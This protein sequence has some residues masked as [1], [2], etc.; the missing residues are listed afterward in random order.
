MSTTYYVRTSGSDSTGNGSIDNPYA[1]I[2]KAITT[3]SNGNIIDVGSGTYSSTGFNTVSKNVTIN[4]PNVGISGSS[5]SRSNEAIIIN[6]TKSIFTGIVTIDGFKISCDTSANLNGGIFQVQS[7]STIQNC[8]FER[9]SVATGSSILNYG[10][11]IT[12]NTNSANYN[13]K[14]NLFI[15]NTTESLFTSSHKSWRSAIYIN[16][17]GRAG[18]IENNVFNNCMT[19]INIDGTGSSIVLK[20]NNFFKCGTFVTYGGSAAGAAQCQGNVY[21]IYSLGAS[22]NIIN[23]SS[24]VDAS[25]VANLLQDKF[26]FDSSLNALAPSELSLEQKFLIEVRLLHKKRIVGSTA[27]N[28]IVRYSNNEQCVIAGLTTIANALSYAPVSGETIYVGPGTYN[29]QVVINKSLTINGSQMDINSINNDG[30]MRNAPN[31]TIVQG[32]TN[33]SGICFTITASNVVINGFKCI[34]PA[35]ALVRDAFNIKVTPAGVGNTSNLQNIVIKN[36]IIQ[37]LRT[38]GQSHAIIFGESTTNL[39]NASN[40]DGVWNNV[41]IANNYF[42]SSIAGNGYRGIQ[43][44][45]HFKT[46]YFN[47]INIHDNRFIHSENITSNRAIGVTSNISDASRGPSYLNSFKIK[48]NY[49]NTP[50]NSSIGGFFDCNGGC[51]ISDN[52]FMNCNYGISSI[53]F[54][55]DGGK[56]Q[57]NTFVVTGYAIGIND[58]VYATTNGSNITIISNNFNGNPSKHI[59]C[60]SQ[61]VNFDNLQTNNTFNGYVSKT[62]VSTYN[63]Y[64]LASSPLLTRVTRSIYPTIQ[65]GIDAP[66]SID[67]SGREHITVGAGTYTENISLAKSVTLQGANKATTIIQPPTSTT[68]ATIQ[69]TDGASGTTIQDVTVKGKYTT[70]TTIGSGNAGNNDSAILF[71]NTNTTTNPEINNINLAN[72]IIQNASN[73]VTF[74]NKHSS[75]ISITGCVIQYNEGCGTRIA[76]NTETMNGFLVDGCTI[77]NNN[78]S[79]ISSNPSGQYRPNCTNYKITNCSI[80][81]NN[82]LTVNNSHDVSFFGFNGDFE[83]SNTNIHCDHAGS[84]LINGSLAT[85]GGWG[86]IINGTGSTSTTYKPSGNI[87]MSNVTMTGNSTKS[88]LGIDRYT[89]LGNISMNNVDIKDC[90]ANKAGQTW[91]QLG[92]GHR[93]T[94][95]MFNLGNTKLRTIYTTSIGD[96]EARNCNFFDI[97]T[98]NPLS[99]TI[100]ELL[101]II[102]QIYDNASNLNIGRV[103][104][105]DS[106]A[107][108]KPGVVDGISNAINSGNATTIYLAVGEHRQ[109]SNLVNF[110][111]TPV[112]IVTLGGEVII[113]K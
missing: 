49:F 48:N 39:N 27:R 77:Q 71:L 37:N 2:L 84:K 60:S 111:T 113:T 92:V 94:T 24:V 45:T 66:G 55:E 40:G 104:I 17:Y 87:T 57:N 112:T 14:N 46:V 89:T 35:S 78:L 9:N 10:L 88:V 33:S 12:G 107:F 21:D 81:N 91:L 79:A 20:N 96:V 101:Q 100:D 82:K 15:S 62:L 102:N 105:V 43:F 22:Y 68:T 86:F 28:G 109:I 73:G 32:N 75:N 31:E 72:L 47:N 26:N 19:A 13:I 23:N 5:A 99:T 29:E 83:M 6:S 74:N 54:R 64:A 106:V 52:T 30:T 38:S 93:D 108:T 85:S 50:S 70:Q 11:E 41:E 69:I 97:N 16:A 58:N 34:L 53:N 65:K 110:Q 25:F 8:I 61:N 98:G 7:S 80:N 1:T 4:G 51:E 95:K 90:E 56:I 36:N 76:S 103:I 59:E 44:S 3:A 63:Q 42:D 67:A 18:N